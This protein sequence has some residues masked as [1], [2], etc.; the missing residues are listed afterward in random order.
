[1]AP[2]PNPDL[3]IVLVEPSHP[4]NI[5]AVARAMMNM[6]LTQLVLVRPREF[7]HPEASARAAGADSVLAN[8]RVVATLQEAIAD[9]GFI[10][11][12][13][14]RDRDQNFRVLEVR[15]AAVR[16]L[17]EA[18]RAPVALLF[19]AERTGL[20]NEHLEAAHVLLRI[21]ASRDYAALNLAM[22]VQLVAYEIFRAR[23]DHGAAVERAATAQV[24][25]LATPPQ[26]QHLFGHLEEVLDEVNF[27]DRTQAGTH[28]MTRIRRFLQRAELDQNEANILRG[29]LT[30]IQGRR[31]MAGAAQAPQTVYLDNAATT[32]V[33]PAVSAL[34][35]AYLGEAGWFANPSAT[36]H[37][38]GRAAAQRIE[39]ARA[40][41][42]R[43]IGAAPAQIIFTSGATEADNLAVLG[44][45]R[46]LA[47]GR[48]HVISARTEHKAVLDAVRQLTREGFSITWVPPDADGRVSAQAVAAALRPDTALVSLMH[49]NNETGVIQDI[50]AIGEVCRS[51]AVLFHVDAAQ[52]A[53]RLALNLAELPVDLLSLSAHKIYGPKGVGALFLRAG[54]KATL[55]PLMFGGGQESGLRPGTLPT[56]QIA[57]FGLACELA[58]EALEAENARITPWRDR[59]RAQL[60]SL[61]NVT[62]NGETAPRVPHILN[63]AF[64]GVEGESLV[65]ALP[66]LAVST[67]A[68]CNSALGEPSYVLRAL[69]RSSRQAESSLRFSIGRF[70][71]EA[72]LEA[73]ASQVRA[74]VRR[75][76]EVSPVGPDTPSQAP[77]AVAAD[78]LNPVVRELFSRLQGAG[79]LPDSLGTVL[80]GEAGGPAAEA[81]VR[82]HLRV[83]AD[84]VIEARFQ[85]LGCPHTLATASW[86]VMQL[87]GRSRSQPQPGSPRAWARTLEV[88]V[89]KLGRLLLIEDAL[90]AALQQWP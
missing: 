12:T 36:A 89:E 33:D 30:A 18:R 63:V 46:A 72:D 45:A 56:H 71:T 9:C 79:A 38:A 49:V 42:A 5:G 8:A 88:P 26:L 21:P 37:A 34:M 40:Q 22:A 57:G 70:N 58:G 78:T 50:R 69:G 3:R 6:A 41:V 32:P 29:I 59:L 39:L 27:K 31:R 19:G 83:S 44:T 68:A 90:H 20:E 84:T 52:S 53:G 76:R 4:G 55:T 23:A 64:D 75:L 73:A 86:L 48:R 82:L 51:Q 10:V 66:G 60:E 7:P 65:S 80:R 67:G 43:L 2:D 54:A 25:P 14:A 1:M 16:V 13:T 77:L 11:A 35:L 24:V 47:P 17:A 28:L 85:A 61:G 81:W 62:I 74:S 15:E 87:A